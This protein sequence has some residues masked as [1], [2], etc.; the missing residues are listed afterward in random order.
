[1]ETVTIPKEEYEL[2]KKESKLD[3]NLLKQFVES[4]RDIKEGKI[5]RVK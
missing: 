1:M 3:L 2:L 4:F 5:R